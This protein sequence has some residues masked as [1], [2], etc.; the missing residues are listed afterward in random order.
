MTGM[1]TAPPE[2]SPHV[3]NA[4]CYEQWTLKFRKLRRP[5]SKW[6]SFWVMMWFEVLLALSTAQLLQSSTVTTAVFTLTI[7][8]TFKTGEKILVNTNLYFFFNILLYKCLF[9]WYFKCFC[10]VLEKTGFPTHETILE[11]TTRHATCS[12]FGLKFR[13]EMDSDL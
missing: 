7:I 8:L 1:R 13:K 11:M 5:K 6:S 12:H 9:V 3:C 4:S 10:S 2:L